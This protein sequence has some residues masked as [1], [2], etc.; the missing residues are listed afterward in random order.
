VIVTYEAIR[1]WC[2]KCGQHYANQPRRR[3]PRPGDTWHTLVRIP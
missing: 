1:Q 2:R 3:R